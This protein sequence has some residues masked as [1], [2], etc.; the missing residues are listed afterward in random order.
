MPTVVPLPSMPKSVRAG[1]APSWTSPWDTAAPAGQML[2]TIGASASLAACAPAMPSSA[3]R[4][5]GFTATVAV[6]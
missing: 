4:P 6:W 3:A 2:A 1:A 5:P